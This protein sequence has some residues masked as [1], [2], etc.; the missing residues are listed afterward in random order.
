MKIRIQAREKVSYC[1]EMEVDQE[2]LD[3]FVEMATSGDRVEVSDFSLDP[4]CDIDDGELES[5]DVEI[6]VY[7]NGKWESAFPS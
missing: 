6:D 5:E 4:A 3:H 1:K 7:E 2:T